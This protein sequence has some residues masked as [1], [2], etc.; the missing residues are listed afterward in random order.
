MFQ[1]KN[2]ET[3]ITN[4]KINDKIPQLKNKQTN[5]AYFKKSKNK[6]FISS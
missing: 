4:L 3:K 1:L 5:G 6:N 2:N